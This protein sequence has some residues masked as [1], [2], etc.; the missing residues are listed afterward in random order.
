[1]ADK[2]LVEWGANDVLSLTINRPERRNALDSE[3]LHEIAR[4]LSDEG[5]RAGAVIL[6]GAGTEAFSA[7]YDLTQ[8]TGT[9]EDLEADRHI[10]EAATALRSCPA[11]IVARLQGHCH[12]AGVELAMSCDLRIGADRL[13]LSVPAVGLGT[14]YRYPFVAR[15]VQ[16]CGSART[17]DLLLG[18]AEL[19][20]ETAYLWGMLTEV[21]PSA[22]L[23]SRVQAVAD[24]LATAPRAAVRGTKASLNL[25]ERRGVAGEDLVEAL[26][27]RATA[28]GSPERL[29][30]L[31]RRRAKK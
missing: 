5:E 3:T 12:G 16:I 22:D 27:L 15:L 17:S 30:A 18:M 26:Q 23:D 10:G 14:V 11:P 24:R 9:I 25:L 2:L 20:A 7:G 13:Q 4:V 21:V 1:M 28:A 19:D 8:L 31:K 6:R 29:A